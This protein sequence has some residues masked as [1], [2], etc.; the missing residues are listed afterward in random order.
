MLEV[1]IALVTLAS[2]ILY[3]LM[4]GADFGGGIWDLLAGGPR[5]GRQRKHIAEAIAPIWE[6]NH[7]WLILVIVLLFTAFPVAFAVMMTALHIPLT[8][9]LIGIVLRGSA[10]VFRKYDAKDDKVQRRWSLVFGVSSV[11]TPLLQGICLGGL[12]SGAI[13][14]SQNQVTTG[15]LAGWTGSFAIACGVFA[16]A[17]FAF[18]AAVYLTVDAAG[19]VA[20]QNDFRRRAIVAEVTL[21]PIAAAVFFAARHGGASEMYAGLTRWWAPWLLVATSAC[22]LLALFGLFARRFK[23]AR[24][25]AIGQVSLILVGWS[26]AQFP[27]LIVPDVDVFGTAAPQITLRLLVIALGVGALV[28]LPSLYYLFRVFKSSRPVRSGDSEDH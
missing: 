27:H 19:D 20:V 1:I 13:R 9:M 7:V 15:F 22:A 17:L 24:A 4:G 3:A 5:G 10:F 12:A 18:L 6:A 8:V 21:A 26:V 14:V 11:I 2:L 16:V 23:L 28:L 25:A